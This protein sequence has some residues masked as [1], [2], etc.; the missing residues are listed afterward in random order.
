LQVGDVAADRRTASV[1]CVGLGALILF[2]VGI[3]P[4]EAVHNAAH[5]TR[6]A[7]VMPCH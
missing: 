5:D 7:F 3:A 6:H 2:V 1:V 4:V